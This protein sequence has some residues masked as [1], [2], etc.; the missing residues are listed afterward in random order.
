MCVVVDDGPVSPE[1]EC[2]RDGAIC[3]SWDPVTG[4]GRRGASEAQFDP[5]PYSSE[6][7]TQTTY[8]SGGFRN[9]V[10]RE[11]E[12]REDQIDLESTDVFGS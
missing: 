5:N 7:R 11:P 2:G 10:G 1:T 8:S 4:L 9:E 12:T 3:A 6:I